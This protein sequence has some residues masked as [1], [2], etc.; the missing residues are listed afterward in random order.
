MRSRFVCS[1]LA[2][3]VLSLAGAGSVSAAGARVDPEAF[4]GAV[5]VPD[6]GQAPVIRPFKLKGGGAIDLSTFAFD[7]AGQATHL[8]QYAATGVLDPQTFQIQGTMTAADDDT[9]TWVAQ[10]QPGPLGEIQAYLTITGGT[11]RFA[12]AS[13]SASGPVALDPDFMF[14]INLE[15]TIAY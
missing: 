15:G 1:A 14:T 4:K 7:F 8:G 6:Q 9:L 5:V 12:S 13:G 3:T 2:L 10:F 11:G